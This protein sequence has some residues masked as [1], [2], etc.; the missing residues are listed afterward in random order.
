MQL[1]KH[2]FGEKIGNETRLS[3]RLT[4]EDF[5]NDCCTTRVTITRLLCKLKHQGKISFDNKRH[6]IVKDID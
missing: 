2:E 1:L 3:V 6:I 5:A 4:H